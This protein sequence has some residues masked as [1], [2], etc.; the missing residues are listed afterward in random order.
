MVKH[1]HVLKRKKHNDF[2]YFPRPWRRKQLRIKYRL[3]WRQSTVPCLR[4]VSW[5]SEDSMQSK[6]ALVSSSFT[7]TEL[8]LC[9][10]CWSATFRSDYFSTRI[11]SRPQRTDIFNLRAKS[12]EGFKESLSINT[13]HSVDHS[14][15]K[16]NSYLCIQPL[17]SIQ[18]VECS[19]NS[20]IDSQECE[21]RRMD[22]NGKLSGW[23][24][25]NIGMNFC[26][27]GIYFVGLVIKQHAN[28]KK[29]TS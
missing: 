28:E 6:C 3:D 14:V 24:R 27:L 20:Y 1:T 10:R 21:E 17:T 22:I 23:Y 25:S 26:D 7:S 18:R 29:K 8:I 9:R 15:G 19:S 5:Q 13:A 2:T 4:D 11:C 16:R 12:K